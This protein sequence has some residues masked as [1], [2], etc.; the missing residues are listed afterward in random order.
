MRADVHTS[1]PLR[2]TV[3][4]V[5]LAGLDKHRTRIHPH[6]CGV[7][8][9]PQTP[10]CSLL[11]SPLP[12]PL[13]TN[14]LRLS[15]QFYLLWNMVIVGTKQYC[16][17]FWKEYFPLH[18]SLNPTAIMNLDVCSH[19]KN[20]LCVYIIYTHMSTYIYEYTFMN[21]Y[22]FMNNIH[23]ILIL[24]FYI[25]WYSQCLYCYIFIVKGFLTLRSILLCPI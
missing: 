7:F 3:Y 16:F 2:V 17:L 8:L 21:K 20:V 22:Q 11:H 5:G 12:Q 18:S 14:D 4:M 25:F 23:N 19:L 24:I 13:A 10:L 1:S 15:T 9:L 6:N